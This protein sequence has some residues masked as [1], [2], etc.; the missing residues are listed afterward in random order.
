LSLD[1][2]LDAVRAANSAFLARLESDPVADHAEPLSKPFSVVVKCDHDDE[3]WTVHCENDSALRDCAAYTSP[4]PPSVWT[5]G[6]LIKYLKG[7]RWNWILFTIY[8]DFEG[9]RSHNPD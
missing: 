8:Q 1:P 4:L 3:T 9:V 2:T 7:E 5:R 6:E